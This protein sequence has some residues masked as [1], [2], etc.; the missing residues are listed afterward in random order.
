MGDVWNDAS[1][2]ES[3]H[4]EAYKAGL[5]DVNCLFEWLIMYLKILQDLDMNIMM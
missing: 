5:L 4:K 2:S 3:I 1:F